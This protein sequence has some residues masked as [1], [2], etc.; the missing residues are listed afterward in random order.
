MLERGFD[1]SQV[2]FLIVNRMKQQGMELKETH[3]GKGNSNSNMRMETEEDIC[4]S[5]RSFLKLQKI[6]FEEEEELIRE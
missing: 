3:P 2:S 5:L 4:F 1:V 6:S